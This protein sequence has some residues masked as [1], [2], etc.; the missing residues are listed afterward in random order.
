V[1]FRSKSIMAKRFSL[2]V[3]AK[4]F[5]TDELEIPKNINQAIFY[6]NPKKNILTPGERLDHIREEAVSILSKINDIIG[7]AIRENESIVLEGVHLFPDFVNNIIIQHGKD[8]IKAVFIGSDNI[9]LIIGGMKKNKSENNWLKESDNDVLLQVAAF[10]GFFSNYIS[11]E[12]RKHDL[13]Y[14]ERSNDFEHDILDVMSVL[15]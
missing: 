9:E 12:C 11:A 5:S 1:L 4:L 14:K 3:K 2:S 8:N 15:R 13:L 6:G 7:K 10:T